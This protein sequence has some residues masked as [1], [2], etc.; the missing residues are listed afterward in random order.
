VANVDSD[1]RLVCPASQAARPLAWSRRPGRVEGRGSG[2]QTLASV[3]AFAITLRGSRP[4]GR[5]ANHWPAPLGAPSWNRA[6]PREVMQIRPAEAYSQGCARWLTVGP[7]SCELDKRAP[8]W[9]TPRARRPNPISSP[10]A[11]GNNDK[12]AI[13]GRERVMA[14]ERNLDSI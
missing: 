8:W 4:S 2:E 6:G 9:P 12:F 3:I 13:G 5:A 14:L 11:I 1:R 7:R 10:V